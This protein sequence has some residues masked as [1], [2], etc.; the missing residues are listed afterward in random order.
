MSE[1]T[2][3]VTAMPSAITATKFLDHYARAEAA[4]DAAS[5]Q[6]DPTAR[7]RLFVEAQTYIALA[8]VEAT[9]IAGLKD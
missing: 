6:G 4:V 1:V 3:K 5:K 7:Q 2:V 8:Q 9:W